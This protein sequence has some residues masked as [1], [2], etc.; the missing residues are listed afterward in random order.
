M[1]SVLD[2]VCSTSCVAD[3]VDKLYFANETTNEIRIKK[4][5]RELEVR[6]SCKNVD[7]IHCAG[8]WDGWI[9]AKRKEGSKKIVIREVNINKYF[10]RM[11]V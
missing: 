5:G 3:S 11:R 7:C 9:E 6:N 2:Q 1:G 8:L 4:N 10:P